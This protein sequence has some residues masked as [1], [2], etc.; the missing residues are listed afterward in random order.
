MQF[1]T[2]GADAQAANKDGAQASFN[3]VAAGWEPALPS[4]NCP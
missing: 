3:L 2:E 1:L 4:W